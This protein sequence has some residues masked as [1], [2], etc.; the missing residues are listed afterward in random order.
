MQTSE[1]PT[2]S[3]KLG[4]VLLNGLNYKLTGENRSIDVE[5]VSDT[6]NVPDNVDR[7]YGLTNQV[8]GD[9][10]GGAWKKNKGLLI[11]LGAA[12]LLTLIIL[13]G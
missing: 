6:K 2:F 3:T 13:K 10:A 4:D 12:G 9:N 8:S 1:G 5:R 11:G 7:G